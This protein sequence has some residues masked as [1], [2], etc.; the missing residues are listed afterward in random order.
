MPI[1]RGKQVTMNVCRSIKRDVS[2]GEFARM[3][4]T[5]SKNPALHRQAQKAIWGDLWPC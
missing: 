4:I 2:K 5:K 3:V 1:R